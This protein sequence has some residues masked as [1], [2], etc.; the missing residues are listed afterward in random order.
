MLL[1][2]GAKLESKSNSGGTL[3]SSAAENGHEA[4]VKQLLEKGGELES[5]D[6]NGQTPLSRAS[7]NGHEEVVKA[8]ARERR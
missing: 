5:E 7:E 2:K 8:V 6:E 3:L 4:V 1:E